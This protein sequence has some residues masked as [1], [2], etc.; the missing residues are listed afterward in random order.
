MRKKSNA[1]YYFF[2]SASLFAVLLVLVVYI[3]PSNTIDQKNTNAIKKETAEIE[4]QYKN[5]VRQIFPEIEG[6][7]ESDSVDSAKLQEIRDELLSLKVTKQ[8]QEL[9]V[10]MVLA[11]DGYISGDGARADN[12]RKIVREIKNNNPWLTN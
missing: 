2:F 11:V 8:Y 9:H 12:S 4:A 6:V 3:F 7:G 1:I 5:S 10:N